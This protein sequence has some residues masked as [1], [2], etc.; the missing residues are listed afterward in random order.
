V[1]VGLGDLWRRTGSTRSTG[2]VSRS[3]L[4]ALR[5][6]SIVRVR[7]LVVEGDRLAIVMD[8]VSGDEGG[9]PRSVPRSAEAVRPPGPRLLD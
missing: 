2:V 4:L 6:P 5:H 3:V 9:P 7:D 1:T 8:L